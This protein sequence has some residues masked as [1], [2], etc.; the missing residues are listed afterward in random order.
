MFLNCPDIF[1]WNLKTVKL[2]LGIMGQML[3][4]P[5]EVLHQFTPAG[6]LALHGYK[7]QFLTYDRTECVCKAVPRFVTS[8]YKHFATC[9]CSHASVIPEGKIDSLAPAQPYPVVHPNLITQTTGSGQ[10][11]LAVT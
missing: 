10:N 6:N 5:L 7:N 2:G 11:G 4:W 8:H 1:V 9:L 3:C